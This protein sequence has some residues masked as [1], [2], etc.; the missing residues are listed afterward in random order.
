MSRPFETRA[1]AFGGRLETIQALVD[2]DGTVRVYDS[3][4][5]YYTTFHSL[6]EGARRRIRRLAVAEVAS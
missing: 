4:A 5:G 3:V 2:A 6:S 1:R